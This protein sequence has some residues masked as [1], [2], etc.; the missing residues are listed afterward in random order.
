MNWHTNPERKAHK[1]AVISEIWNIFVQ[2]ICMV[3]I[4]G[5]CITVDEQPLG[6]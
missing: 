3:L 6:Y 2:N 1:F 5:K 4:P